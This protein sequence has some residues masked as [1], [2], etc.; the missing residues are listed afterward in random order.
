MAARRTLITGTG[1]DF[2]LEN[3]AI[4]K[5]DEELQKFNKNFIN[6]ATSIFLGRAHF[7]KEMTR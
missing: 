1:K 7:W 2:S 5:N 4:C 3:D 6:I